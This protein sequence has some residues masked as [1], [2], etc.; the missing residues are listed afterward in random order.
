MGYLAKA[1]PH[2]EDEMRVGIWQLTVDRAEYFRE[3]RA[4]L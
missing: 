1:L 3:R 2:L 4:A